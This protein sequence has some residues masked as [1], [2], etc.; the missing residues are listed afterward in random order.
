MRRHLAALAV[1]GVLLFTACSGDD[2]SSTGPSYQPQ[3]QLSGTCNPD[4]T[5]Q[6]IIELF[7]K[8]ESRSSALSRF[9]QVVRTA[10]ANPPG[11][12]PAATRNHALRLVD[13]VLVRYF[14]GRLIG[15]TSTAT[16]TKVAQML[17]GVLCL[18][19]LPPFNPAALGLDAAAVVV[20]PTS[21]QTTIV[22]GTGFAGAQVETGAVSEPTLFTITRLPDSPGPLLT[23]FDQYPLFYEYH[24]VGTTTFNVPVVV[25]TCVPANITPPDI[26]RLRLAHNVAPFTMGSIEILEP[27]EGVTFVDCTTAQLGALQ[28]SRIQELAHQ[29]FQL[30]KST[31]EKAILPAPLYAARFFG[32]GGLSGSVRTFS[33]FGGVDPV[34]IL[35]PDND[36]VRTPAFGAFVELVPAV[37]L[38][39]PTGRA[40]EGLPVS[41]TVAAGGGAVGNAVINTD[42][43]GFASAGSWQFG[44]T[45]PQTL[46]ATVGGIPANASITGSPYQFNGIGH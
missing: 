12:D 2:P 27:V 30:L 45:N 46:V 11:P 35:T 20:D 26:N 21:P 9:K 17:T 40:M 43:N 10:G 14:D 18:A 5:E 16:A 29:G 39:T 32:T 42:A 34:G 31:L 25:S 36:F 22:T 38:T 4:V 41:W 6:L 24:A 3:Q 7:A 37:T 44:F 13:F 33:P 15:G 8:G 1:G 23:Q 19:G 28:R